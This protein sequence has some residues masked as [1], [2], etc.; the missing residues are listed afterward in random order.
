MQNCDPKQSITQ[1][2][3]RPVG[4]TSTVVILNFLTP[5]SWFTI[6]Y[7]TSGRGVLYWFPTQDQSAVP[8]DAGPKLWKYRECWT[9]EWGL[10]FVTNCLSKMSR[11]HRGTMSFPPLLSSL[12]LLKFSSTCIFMEDLSMA[13][14]CVYFLN[15]KSQCFQFSICPKLGSNAEMPPVPSQVKL[16]RSTHCIYIPSKL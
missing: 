11:S 14:M 7:P 6:I 4:L 3:L 8:C 9:K 10:R 1:P 15:N 12:C 16:K 5:C 2:G 13:G